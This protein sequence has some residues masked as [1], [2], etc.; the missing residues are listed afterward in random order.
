[1]M[2][3]VCKVT[4]VTVP[5]P[6]FHSCSSQ[7][8]LSVKSLKLPSPNPTCRG[9]SSNSGDFVFECELQL[10]QVGF[11]KTNVHVSVSGRETSFGKVRLCHLARL[12]SIDVLE[13]FILY[14]YPIK[15][16]KSE[17]RIVFSVLPVW[18]LF[19]YCPLTAWRQVRK[20]TSVCSQCQLVNSFH[21]LF[22]LKHCQYVPLWRFLTV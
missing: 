2:F 3:V 13:W 21:G 9:C 17:A 18:V 20:M 8:L 19:A 6:T 16:L 15:S 4:T 10:Q 7:G 12:K 11:G 14:K 1:M 22:V 5:K